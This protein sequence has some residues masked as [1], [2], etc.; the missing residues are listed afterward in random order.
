MVGS[1]ARR[2]PALRDESA[3]QLLVTMF[4]AYWFGNP[5]FVPSALLVALLGAFGIGEPA[6]RA[7]LSRLSRRGDLEATR[8][9]RYTAYRL[10]P[11]SF[12]AARDQ[13]SRMLRF[14]TPRAWDQRW[15]CVVFSIPEAARGRRPALRQR[16]RDLQLGPLFDGFWITPRAPLDAIDRMLRDLDVRDAAV[17][18]VREVPRPEGVDLLSAWDLAALRAGYDGLVAHVEPVLREL[19]AGTLAG[20]EALVR[21]VALCS[22]WRALAQADPG[23][24][25]EL[26]P[27]DW[28]QGRARDLFVEAFD[29]LGPPAEQFVRRLA[30]TA[31][32]GRSTPAPHSRCMADCQAPVAAGA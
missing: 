12:A 24:P 27:A 30:A 16:L 3:P 28:P 23:L 17:F 4:L 9:G 19:R 5:E 1:A 20:D 11:A 15:T 10:A 13:G 22:R 18:R 26:L 14:G 25:P 29:T 21:R 32:R 7:A 8:T 2:D 6:A 31:A